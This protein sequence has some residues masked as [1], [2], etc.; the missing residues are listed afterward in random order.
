MN[1]LIVTEDQQFKMFL[2]ERVSAEGCNVTIAKTGREALQILKA[3][4]IHLV[5]TEF[6]LPFMD[7]MSFCQ[8]ARA[9]DKTRSIP[10][11]ISFKTDAEQKKLALEN[12][13]DCTFVPRNSLGN[14]IGDLLSTFTEGGPDEF[15]KSATMPVEE[16]AP[17][18]VAAETNDTQATAIPG[19]IPGSHKDVR[20]LLVDDEDPF[21]MVLHDLLTDEGYKNVT[22]A[23]DGREAIELLKHDRFD[24]VILDLIMPLVSGFGVLHFIRDHADGTKVIMLTAYADIK[25]A[26]EATK[27]GASDFIAK[28]VMRKDFFRTVEQV[29]SKT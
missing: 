16:E 6:D 25:L 8:M 10:F 7:G 13:G 11:I 28:P 9:S 27:L 3:N 2:R 1:V 15:V 29:L 5:I 20:I 4:K 24:L 23:S 12:I 14:S 26:V 22:E 21:R 19:A 18:P 17:V